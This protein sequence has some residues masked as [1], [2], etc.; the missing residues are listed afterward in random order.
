MGIATHEVVIN[1]KP[2]LPSG[3]WGFSS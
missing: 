3:E 1:A 2:C